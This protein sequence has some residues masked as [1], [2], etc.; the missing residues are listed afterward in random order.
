MQIVKLPAPQYVELYATLAEQIMANGASG[1]SDYM[2]EREEG[3]GTYTECFT[4]EGQDIFNDFAGIVM[5]ILAS[6]GVV[7]E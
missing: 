4:E 2:T 1:M 7:C 6:N 5:D 3:D